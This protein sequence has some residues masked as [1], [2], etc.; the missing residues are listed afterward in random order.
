MG[1][2]QV[3]GL[4]GAILNSIIAAECDGNLHCGD[5]E[6]R[7]R[8]AETV[9]DGDAPLAQRRMGLYLRRGS[10]PG[11]YDFWLN[12]LNNSGGGDPGNYRA[13]VCS[14]I[15]SRE[16][17]GRFSRVVTRTNGECSW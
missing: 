17:Q 4:F 15:T 2:N 3:L 13:M 8:I 9:R 16:Y 14:F 10:D 12:V 11:G 1:R 6:L 7:I 5:D